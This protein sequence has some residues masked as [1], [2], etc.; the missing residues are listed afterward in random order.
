MP[1]ANEQ[2]ARLPV[3]GT[4][5]IDVVTRA[6]HLL[7]VVFGVAAWLSGDL[8]DYEE[9]GFSLGFTLHRWVG[10]AASS[11]VG[12]RII[13]GAIGPRGARFSSW[14]PLTR[15]RWRLVLE[16]MGMLLRLRLPERAAHE[17]LAGVVQSFGVL[18]FAWTAAT[19]SVLFFWLEPGVRPGFWLDLVKELHGVAETLIPVFLAVHVGATVVHALAGNTRW[20]RM[21]FLPIEQT[22]Q[23]RPM[24]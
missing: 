13:W 19:G 11:A 17:G 14:T 3:R 16:D 1:A 6:L 7:L 18:V 24:P 8:S 22:T 20:R 5:D 4:D 15:K 21:L 2:I 23:Q 12:L 9:R 10:I